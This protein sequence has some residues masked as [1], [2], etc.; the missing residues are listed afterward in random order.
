M[1]MKIKNSII[2]SM[3]NKDSSTI[4][5]IDKLFFPSLINNASKNI[6]LIVLD[7]A[8]PIKRET[9]LLMEKYLLRL[10]KGFGR[11]VLKRNP[12]NLGFAGSFNK[13]IRMAKGKKLFI[14][15]DDIY[16]PK[17]SVSSLI[18][19]LYEDD[20][21]GVVGP[22]VNEK[23]V[24]TYQY[25]KQSPMIESYSDEELKKIESFAELLRK[26]MKGQRIKTDTLSGFCFV[27]DASR[28]RKE[29]CF[30]DSYKNGS[31]EDTDLFKR[32]KTKYELIVNPE[33]F[34]YH[35]GLHGAHLSL[36]QQRIKRHYNDMKNALTFAREWGYLTAIKH[37]L[38][39]IYRS[40]GKNTISELFEEL[41]KV[42]K[43]D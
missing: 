4:E 33:V 42:N 7:D 3:Y 15:N 9:A 26:L 40:T 35:G 25:C 16:L 32:I 10:R 14:V 34:V 24:W 17:G 22:I 29:G 6:E 1:K 31:F 20:S 18:N 37:L 36:N 21:Y 30:C 23:D 5:V 2:T 39:G 38:L 11:V 27:A 8:S 19:T 28:L 13:G 12:F 43:A 41:S